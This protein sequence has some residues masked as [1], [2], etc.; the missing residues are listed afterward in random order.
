MNMNLGKIGERAIVY[1]GVSLA[2]YFIIRYVRF[3]IL[4]IIEANTMQIDGMPGAWFSSRN[5]GTRTIQIGLGILGESEFHTDIFDEWLRLS[6]LISKDKVA[7][8][9]IGNGLYV[10]AMFT[11]ESPIE[12]NHNWSIVELNFECFDPFIYGKEHEEPIKTGNNAITV[13]GSKKTYPVFNLT[14]SGTTVTVRNVSTGEQVRIT[15][16]SSGTKI[17]V[18]MEQ[19]KVTMNGSFK[20]IDPS[21]SD[22]WPIEAGEATIN[23]TGATGTMTYKERYL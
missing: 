3:P 4:P 21:V 16:V 17:V 11:G 10:N 5:I 9:E 20:A 13:D 7:K 2:D 15:G 14:A 12:T 23:V 19:Y 22:F 8:L 1:D 18:D 6:G